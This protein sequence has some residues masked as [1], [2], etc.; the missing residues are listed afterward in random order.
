MSKTQQP[1]DAVD[2]DRIA[3]II[4][5]AKRLAM[6]YRKVTGKPLGLT[7]EIGEYEAA[8]I[9]DLDLATARTPGY[10]ARD[11]CG[12][13]YQIKTRVILTYPHGSYQSL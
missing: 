6:E 7:G 9:L 12:R 3:A 5:Q 11:S 4:K 13:R 10:D 8:A 1:I 2:P